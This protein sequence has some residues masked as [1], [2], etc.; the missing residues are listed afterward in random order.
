MSPVHLKIRIIGNSGYDTVYIEIKKN[1]WASVSDLN[2]V[3]SS[4]V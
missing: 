3:V 2:L 1:N 4:A